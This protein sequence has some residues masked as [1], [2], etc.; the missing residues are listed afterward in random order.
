M[1]NAYAHFMNILRLNF[2]HTDALRINS[3]RVFFNN[4]T[5]SHAS[6]DISAETKFN[7]ADIKVAQSSAKFMRDAIIV[8]VVFFQAIYYAT[9]DS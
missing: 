3:K 5:S 6:R 4:P 7:V 1:R 2:T 9:S 8:F